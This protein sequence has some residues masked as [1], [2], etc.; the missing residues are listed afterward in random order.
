M[1]SSYFSF[2]G[3]WR[4]WD[5]FFF[6]RRDLSMC[7]VIRIAFSSLLLINLLVLM[8]DLETW[9][10]VEGCLPLGASRQ[11]IDSDTI[12]LFQWLPESDTVLWTCFGVF[13]LQVLCLLVG[14]LSRFQAACVF[15]WLVSFQH[16]NAIILDG[17]DT[18]FR[19]ICFLLIFMPAGGY[20]SLDS[21]WRARRGRVQENTE[22]PVWPLR[23]LQ[24]EMSLIYLSTA[25]EKL[26]GKEWINGTA[27]YYVS[28][29][30][31]LF[32]RFWV[33][34][35]LFDS[36]P[37]LI[38][39]TWLVLAFELLVPFALWFEETRRVALVV[40][41]TFHLAVDYT[42]NLF[43]FQWIMM[44]GLLS[45][46]EPGDVRALRVRLRWR[47]TKESAALSREVSVTES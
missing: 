42:M 37:I 34:S 31:D 33:P 18:V 3:L 38:I 16:R 12:T 39:M 8:P 6:V 32:G 43:L 7:G 45:F 9:F 41:F 5:R 35:V 21:C 23:L 13:F 28:R 47:S 15:L 1:S 26:D 4:R 40:A 36:M 10:G 29:L 25:L 17:E 44:V 24:I 11:V 14:F 22:R 46:V 30:D 19:L 2:A 27:L 20:L